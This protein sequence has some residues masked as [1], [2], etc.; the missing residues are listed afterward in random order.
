MKRSPNRCLTQP[1]LYTVF[2]NDIFNLREEKKKNV[3]NPYALLYMRTRRACFQVIM[4][5]SGL[6]DIY[7]VRWN[8][9]SRHILNI[10][11]N[12]T[13]SSTTVVHY[14]FCYV[15]YYTRS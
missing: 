1:H 6:F 9:T 7:L 12:V 15:Q 2:E 5:T 4:S 13:V 11:D 14:Y 3:N 8:N 10:Y